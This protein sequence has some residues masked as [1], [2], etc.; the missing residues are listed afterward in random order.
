MLL[1]I[2]T[3]R[4]EPVNEKRTIYGLATTSTICEII[5]WNNIGDNVCG[6]DGVVG[7]FLF[8]FFVPKT[9]RSTVIFFFSLFSRPFVTRTKRN[10]WNATF[11]NCVTVD[12]ALRC[13]INAMLQSKCEDKQV[14]LQAHIEID[15]M[16]EKGNVRDTRANIR[17]ELSSS[18]SSSRRKRP[19]RGE[20]KR[21]TTVCI[22]FWFL[23][24]QFLDHRTDST[25]CE[26]SSTKT[27]M[28]FVST[29]I[30]LIVRRS[31][32][33]IDANRQCPKQTTSKRTK[34]ESKFHQT[35]TTATTTMTKTNLSRC[36]CC[37]TL[38]QRRQWQR[39]KTFPNVCNS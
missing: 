5:N 37:L 18:S 24:Q 10:R 14:Q 13:A 8:S 30:D 21:Q 31:N 22:S 9:K 33:W 3:S 2:H 20:R 11:G 12:D 23:C 32:T 26:C 7:D 19:K 28:H 15:S 27:K 38:D 35:M 39:R 36:C 4:R 17:F 1:C 25:R 29:G 16:K 6:R 34:N